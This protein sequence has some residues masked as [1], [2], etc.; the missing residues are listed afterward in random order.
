MSPY[1]EAISPPPSFPISD[2]H[3]GPL[4]QASV[5]KASCRRHVSVSLVVGQNMENVIFSGEIMSLNP[6]NQNF[7]F[8]SW[9][10]EEMRDAIL[11][12]GRSISGGPAPPKKIFRLRP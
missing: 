3:S 5:L 4:I 2:S 1:T 12:A 9:V 10:H 6:R 8:L 11:R 7:T